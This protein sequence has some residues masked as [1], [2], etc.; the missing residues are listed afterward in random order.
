MFT[1]QEL[2][3]IRWL[4]AKETNIASETKQSIISKIDDQL[5]GIKLK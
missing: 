1:I 5:N 3:A 2:R 4:I